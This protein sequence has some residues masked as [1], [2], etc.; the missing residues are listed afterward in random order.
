MGR[1]LPGLLLL[2]LVI[3]GCARFAME[4]GVPG[5]P[6]EAR[7]ELIAERHTYLDATVEAGGE[8][9]RFFFPRSAVCR[10]VLASAQVRFQLA[11]VLGTARSAEGEC[12]A[13][14]ILSLRAWRDR[15]GRAAHG[16]SRGS[17]VPS[18]RI[19]YQIVY[20]DADLFLAEGRF[21]LAAQIGWPGGADAIAVFPRVDACR[22]VRA[23]RRGTME[24]RAAGNTPFSV[25]GEAGRCP[26]LGFAQILAEERTGAGDAPDSSRVD[27]AGFGT[28]RAAQGPGLRRLK[29]PDWTAG[30]SPGRVAVARSGLAGAA[31]G[32]R[33]LRA[34]ADEHE[35][36]AAVQAREREC[37]R[38][39]LRRRRVG[40]CGAL[41]E[42][43]LQRIPGARG[44]VEP[45]GAQELECEP[46]DRRALAIAGVCD[47]VEAVG[48]DVAQE[49]LRI[50]SV[51]ADAQIAL[52][53]ALERGLLVRALHQDHE[54]AR[55]IHALQHPGG[56][57]ACVGAQAHECAAGFG[58]R[59]RAQQ[60]PRDAPILHVR[61]SG[62][63]TDPLA[64]ARNEGCGV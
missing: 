64:S 10:R 50:L 25:V 6:V 38:S 30:P 4:T 1:R 61:T 13:V 44:D 24:F 42:D 52:E 53:C 47:E 3:L 22:V 5:V 19:E 55:Q 51:N 20:D 36:A 34:T 7:V 31:S 9:Y 63:E 48:V 14:G 49:C 26:V 29:P 39:Q 28:G 11:G 56:G 15:Q 33:A 59:E 46:C 16:A 62:G 45:A 43:L 40:C 35:V 54:A 21:R 23:R 58:R 17:P 41:R 57:F 18:D 12:P 8:H 37:V 32:L 27:G 2:L 60:L